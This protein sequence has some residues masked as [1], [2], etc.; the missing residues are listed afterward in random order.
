MS[1]ENSAAAVHRFTRLVTSCA[2]EV[3]ACGP[4]D[5]SSDSVTMSPTSAGVTGT[6][7]TRPAGSRRSP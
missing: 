4:H 7:V 5:G 1:R 2:Q 3:V 6:N